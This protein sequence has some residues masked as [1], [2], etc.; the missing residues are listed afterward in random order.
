[1]TTVGFI[2]LGL[3]GNP[4][5][6]R[7]ISAGHQLVVYNRS[8]R[9][10]RE[11]VDLGAESARNPREVGERAEIVITMLPDSPDVKRV[12]LG[13]D[14]VASGLKKGAVVVDCSTISPTVEVEIAQQ[15]LTNGVEALDAPVSGGTTG[16]ESGTLT[17]MVGGSA[18][19]YERC[20][21]LFKAMGKSI[22]HMG[23]NGMGS[24]TKLCNQ[25][26]V[27]LNLLGTCEAL[28]LASRAGLDPK[29]TI[30]VLGTSAASSLQLLNFG[31]KM[32]DRDFRPGFKIQHLKK[33]LRIVSETCEKLSLPFMGTALVHELLKAVEN[34]GLGESGTP[35]LIVALE[36]LA[37][38]E[39]GQ[40][41]S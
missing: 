34:E 40:T 6:K 9:P 4:M 35:A 27:S 3:M 13:D 18:T 10:I 5:S 8:S 7:L 1:M 28:M 37:G 32:L 2:G 19:A 41:K 38:H 12:I 21:P 39:I 15:L 20:V 14:G 11:L 22:F 16:A 17:F 36:K 26:C 33:D 23:T 29:R 30:E 31:P 25:I 24:F